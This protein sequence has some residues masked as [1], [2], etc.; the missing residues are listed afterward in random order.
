M[1]VSKR[2]RYEILRRDNHA[3]RYCGATAPN[4]TLNVDHVIPK[5][6]GG[7]DKPTNLVTSCADC[8]AGK[9]SSMPNAEPVADVDQEAF[10]ES[11]SAK[12]WQF[13]NV[14]LDPETGMPAAWS[15]LEVQLAMV[16]D[17]WQTAWC[18]VDP[19]G[20]SV[21][22]WEALYDQRQQLVDRGVYIGNILAAA[23]IAGSRQSTQLKWGV[24]SRNAGIWPDTEEFSLGCDAVH[25]WEIAWEQG[26]GDRPAGRA[27]TLFIEEVT[28]AIRAGHHRH[29]LIQ[30]AE[31]AG[32]RGHFYL[33]VY[34]PE[35]ETAGGEN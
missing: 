25:A 5:S 7:S 4:V 11:A 28:E 32:R 26:V 8:N 12:R 21:A 2:L 34:L 31:A 22:D 29:E 9:T 18:A 19:E 3:C 30:A 35:R 16:E 14:A 6:L 15:F 33:P 23:A 24:P 17:V 27:T 13:S 20:P 10:R 1:A